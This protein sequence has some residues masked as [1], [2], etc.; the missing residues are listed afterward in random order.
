M[1]FLRSWPKTIFFGIHKYN[2]WNQIKPEHPGTMI[3][4]ITN[5]IMSKD[6][7]PSN[8]CSLR[9]VGAQP[10]PN[11]GLMM[12]Q[13]VF[14][15]HNMNLGK[16]PANAPIKPN[17]AQGK[18]G[19]KQN[20]TSAYLD[21]GSLISCITQVEPSVNVINIKGPNTQCVV[22]THQAWLKI[23]VPSISMHVRSPPTW[24]PPSWAF[25]SDS[26]SLGPQYNILEHLGNTLAQISILDLLR[27]RPL[28]QEILDSTL[29][30]SC[31]PSNINT[32][33]FCNLVSHLSASCSLSFKTTDIPAV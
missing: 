2:P 9:I 33:D 8:S 14:P 32:T 25:P 19:D 24:P 6:T 16:A 22:A 4:I 10:S 26:H 12:Y 28:Y 13:N 23:T 5:S 3:R 31:I 17:N 27:T 20:Y 1:P 29:C 11:A 18:Q 21:Y 30:E 7:L 15:P